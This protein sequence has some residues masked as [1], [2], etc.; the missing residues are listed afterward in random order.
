MKNLYLLFTLLLLS[1]PAVSQYISVDQNYTAQ[2]LVEDVLFSNSCA[3]VSNVT[4]SGGNFG[5][6][7]KSWGYFNRNGSAFELEEGIILSTGKINN[8]VGPNSSL[9][10]DDAPNWNGDS[11][12]NQALS[13]SNSINATILE[14][15]FVPLGD[16]ISFEYIFSSEEYHDTAPCQYSDGFAFLLRE[17]GTTPYENLAL[18]PGTNIPVKVTTVHPEIF[19]G[20][21]GENEQYFGSYNTF[22]HPTNYNG[23]TVTL[24]AEADVTPGTTYHIKLVIAD[25]GNYRYDSAIFLKGGSFS[26]VGT[27]GNDRTLALNNPVCYDETFSLDATT[28]GVTTYQWYFNGSILNGENSPILNF[29]P[30]YNQLMNGNY[31]VLLGFGSTCTESMKI[32]LDFTEELIVNE[33]TYTKCDDDNAQNG[34]SYFTN[35]DLLAIKNQLFNSLPSNYT[36]QLFDNI[37]D[38]TPITIPYYNNTPYTHTIYGKITN[39]NCYAPIPITLIVNIFEDEIPDETLS[40]CSGSSVILQ[41]ET[42]YN[43]IWSSGETTSS[44]EV[45]NAG[46]YSVEIINTNECSTI[47]NFTVLTSEIATIVDIIVN[48]FS[49]NN[50]AEIIVSGNGDYEYSLDGINYQDNPIFYNLETGEYTVFVNDKNGCGIASA[51]FSIL[52]YPNFFTPNGDGFNDTWNIKN[53]EKRGLQESKIFIFDR[54]GK[55]LKQI[56]P[57]GQ[58]WNG[59]INGHQ[60]PSEDYWFVLELTNGKTIKGHF[61]LKR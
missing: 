15:D 12:L 25:E 7:E 34:I 32:N 16:K 48:D 50:T 56:S 60:V 61:A 10:D 30:P 49:S 2:Q 19:N 27:L 47:K 42:G 52:D 31:S 4:V 23:Q 18:I 13:I 37:N 38:T 54:Y 11:D 57:E 14:F 36:L 39:V 53:L 33:S 20:C 46:T 22:N 21:D 9:S 1:T 35:G 40:I 51:N 3:S 24:K 26:S 58:G 44:I 45:S 28:A 29:S 17:V 5:T 8:A 59:T 43:Y 55:L 41:A 6:G